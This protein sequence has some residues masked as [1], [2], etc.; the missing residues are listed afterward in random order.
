VVVVVAIL[1]LFFDVVGMLSYLLVV[2]GIVS[3]F[4]T[5][6][7]LGVRLV[8][9]RRV[10][11]VPLLYPGTAIVA[12]LAG[13]FAGYV[14]GPAPVP[15]DSMPPSEQLAYMHRVDQGD[16]VTLRFLNTSR[17]DQRL[18]RTRQL[19]DAGHVTSPE[20][21]LNAAMVF[22]H[23]NDSSDYRTAY[24]LASAACSTGVDSKVWPEELADWL[25]RAA[26]DRWMLSVGRPQEYGTQK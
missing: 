14:S 25:R 8:L 3:G 5:A 13:L 4:V 16:R 18:A 6:V 9:R 22:Q 26:Y 23:G 12:G 21:R 11:A 2:L 10:F 24:E 20:D 15:P 1:G 19:L 17:D 7:V